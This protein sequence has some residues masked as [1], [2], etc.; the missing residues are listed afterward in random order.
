MSADIWS[1]APEGATHYAP[2][3][4]DSGIWCDVYWRKDGDSFPE[5]WRVEDS[6][7]LSNIKNPT[8]IAN[9][10][11]RM[12]PRPGAWC[13]EG[14]PPDGLL[15]EALWPDDA[16][17][18]WCE[19]KF[20]FVGELHAI[21]MVEGEETHYMLGDFLAGD[22]KFR[23]IR[24]PEQIAMEKREKAIISLASLLAGPQTAYQT[25]H[26][27]ATYLYDAGYRKVHGLCS[28]GCID[29]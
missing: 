20:L 7:E 23:P 18:S 3:I 17:P 29:E 15:C 6:G 28:D 16:D 26:E 19:F 2:K 12:I 4:D 13:G 9:S 11:A 8:V 10:L 5:A 24:T 21:A 22:V 27:T 25:Q 1:K 14:L